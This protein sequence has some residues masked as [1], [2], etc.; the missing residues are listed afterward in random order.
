M[1]RYSN[2]TELNIDGRAVSCF[3]E[4]DL[5]YNN[6]QIGIK[7]LGTFTKNNSII[8]HVQMVPGY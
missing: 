1:R 4:F 6:K 3:R 7:Q 5:Y 2:S 8:M